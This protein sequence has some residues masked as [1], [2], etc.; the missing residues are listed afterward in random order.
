MNTYVGNAYIVFTELI[1]PACRAT[2][3]SPAENAGTGRTRTFSA[4][5][6]EGGSASKVRSIKISYLRLFTGSQ[7]GD[8]LVVDQL[9]RSL[10]HTYLF[11]MLYDMIVT[12]LM[13]DSTCKK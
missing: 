10:K 11:R 4:G 9:I 13:L 6:S 12:S 5:E 3:L 1:Y 7:F 8:Q 2:S